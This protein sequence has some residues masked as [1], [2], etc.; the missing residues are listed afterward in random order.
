[1]IR[2]KFEAG[3]CIGE[4]AGDTLG[5]AEVHQIQQFIPVSWP[6]CG[7]SGGYVSVSNVLSNTCPQGD[8][9]WDPQLVRLA[10]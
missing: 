8:V 6:V 5:D 10:L 1:M 9:S 7:F 4:V 3:L 2:G